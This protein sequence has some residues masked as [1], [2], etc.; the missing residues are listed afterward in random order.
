M[1][2]ATIAKRGDK[3]DQKYMQKKKCTVEYFHAK[4]YSYTSIF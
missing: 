4:K 1:V 3:T 2:A